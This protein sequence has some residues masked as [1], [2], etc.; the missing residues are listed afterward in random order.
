MQIDA[1]S[2][3]KVTITS[4]LYCG[5]NPHYVLAVAQLRSGL[6]DTNN[7]NEI[8]PFRLT[9]VQYNQ[10]CTDTEFD[11]NFVPEDIN[12]WYMQIPVF[13]LMA[14]RA[15]DAFALSNDRNPTAAELY[16]QQW[17]AAPSQ[18]L[19]A[20]LTTALTDT[21]RLVDPAAEA[22]IGDPAPP[23][24]LP[25]SHSQPP[26]PSSGPLNLSGF[27]GARLEMARRIQTAFANAGFGKFQ[28]A[29][30]LANA[31]AESS[32]NPNAHAAV[33]EDSWGLFQL[34]RNGGLGQGHNPADLVNPDTNISIVLT[35]AKKYR[36]FV[37]APSIDRAVSA[38]VRDVE[39]PADIGGQIVKRTKIA[40]TY[41]T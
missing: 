34:N 37:S 25:D 20:D 16:V 23:L 9:Q 30:A 6:T 27:K 18:N 3:A 7:G 11:Y 14:H 19:A 17:P 8:G 21:A 5:T 15:F 26:G 24:T 28:Q 12:S 31:V 10:Y 4:A 32:L 1:S 36:E 35:E 33:G 39:R 29:A 2:F 38:F 40:Q 13:A 41:L 22:I